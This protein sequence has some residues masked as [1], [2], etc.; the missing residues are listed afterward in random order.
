MAAAGE[1]WVLRIRLPAGLPNPG[2]FVARLLKYLLRTWG[3]RCVALGE[4]NEVRRLQSI[5]DG[6]ARRISEQSEL[7]SRA[8]EKQSTMTEREGPC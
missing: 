1:L 3:V 6:M 2:R 5:I 8:A 7:L 4:S